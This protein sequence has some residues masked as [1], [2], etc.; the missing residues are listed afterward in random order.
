MTSVSR[1]K[2]HHYVN[3]TLAERFAHHVNKD[4]PI[5]PDLGTPCWLWIGALSH[6][7]GT[8][9]DTNA[10]VSTRT[11]AQLRAHRVSLALHRGERLTPGMSTVARHLCDITACVN[12]DH[13]TDGTQKQN[14][15]DALAKGR[16]AWQKK[17]G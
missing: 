1:G 8:I 13:L 9:R 16:M 14:I 12:P 15:G 6:G 11:N 10:E 2:R 5:H 17:A 7:Y 4:G 3:G